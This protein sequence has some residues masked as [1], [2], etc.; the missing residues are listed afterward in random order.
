MASR[1]RRA[2][3]LGLLGGKNFYWSGQED[4]KTAKLAVGTTPLN[5]VFIG[6]SITY[7]VDASDVL[8]KAFVPILQTELISSHGNGGVFYPA[9]RT[10]YFTYSAGW[11]ELGWGIGSAMRSS[12]TNGDTITFTAYGD[13]IDIYTIDASGNPNFTVTVDSEDPVTVTVPQSL[14]ENKHTVALGAVGSHT[15]VITIAGQ[16]YFDGVSVNIGTSGMRVSNF[17]KSGANVSTYYGNMFSLMWTPVLEPSLSVI[18]L[19]TNDYGSQTAL[20]TYQSTLE[21]IVDACKLQGSVLLVAGPRQQN[22]SVGAITQPQ[23]EAVMQSVALAKGCGYLHIPTHWGTWI[24]ANAN[25]FMAD[26][27]HPT[28]AGHADYARILRRYLNI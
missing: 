16:T 26:S 10:D 22:Q 4:Y 23:Y 20:A 9:F 17:G 13:S 5:L 15:V 11:S 1:H 28:D 8:T 19:T 25:G 6:D 18:G 14:G 21:T 27:I 3:M 7:G 24:Q 12:S 2:M